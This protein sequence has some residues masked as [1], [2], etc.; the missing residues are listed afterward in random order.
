MRLVDSAEQLQRLRLER[1]RSPEFEAASAIWIRSDS[2]VERNKRLVVAPKSEQTKP[3][4]NV[5]DRV[6]RRALQ[7]R[8]VKRERTG[9]QSTAFLAGCTR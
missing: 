9:D 4:A 6:T 3:S 7:N 1:P 5:R 2:G 8:F